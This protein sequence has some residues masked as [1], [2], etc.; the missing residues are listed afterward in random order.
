MAP[1]QRIAFS[2]AARVM[3]SDGFRSS[4]TIWTIRRPVIC[5]MVRRRESTAGIAALPESAIPS[6]SAMLAMV[7][8]VPLVLQVPVD[9]LIDASASRNSSCVISP[10]FTASEN[11]HKCVPEPTRS[12]RNQP[13]SIGPP[14]TTMDGMS[15]DAAP[16]RRLGVVLS[17]PTISTAPSMGWPRIAS[18]T[19]IAARLRNIIAVG[20]KVLSLAENTGTSTGNP[21]AS[22][23]PAFTFS[24]SSCRWPLQG[25]RSDHVF[26]MPITGRPSNRSCG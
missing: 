22:H 21:P 3:M 24:A 8:A 1:L 12:P 26:M 17:Q 25:V 15:V 19:A 2:N 5:A 20:R 11:F 16:I 4:L 9:R 18:S 6:A 23:T 14:V 7:L 10:A 13:L